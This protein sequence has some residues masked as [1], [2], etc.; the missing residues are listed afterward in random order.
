[1]VG[2][3]VQGLNGPYGISSS[4]S[5]PTSGDPRWLS[6]FALPL[7]LLVVCN[8]YQVGHPLFREWCEAH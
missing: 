4:I 8:C 6:R 3:I 1:M 5:V 2:R 7:G